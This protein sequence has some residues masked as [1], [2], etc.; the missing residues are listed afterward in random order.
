MLSLILLATGVIGVAMLAMALGTIL[1]SRCLR[2]SC[3]GPDLLDPK[4]EML[5]CDTCPLRTG[6]RREAPAATRGP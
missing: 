4:G 5:T 6:P 2:G 3:G 1:S